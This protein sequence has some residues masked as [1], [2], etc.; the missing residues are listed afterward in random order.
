M[1]VLLADDDQDQLHLR[2]MVLAKSGFEIFEASDSASALKTAKEQKPQCAV[3]DLRF[4]TQALGLALIR[5]LKALDAAMRVIVLTGSDPG[6]LA[7]LPEKNLIDEVMVKGAGSARLVAKLREMDGPE[8]LEAFRQNGSI[9]LEVRVIPRSS[10]SEV[11]E[12]KEDGALKVKLCA[13]PEKGHANEELMVVL[14][15]YFEV[16]K[17]NVELLSGATSRRKRVRI[18]KGR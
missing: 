9:T 14:A 5:A 15:E 1:R 6:K 8:I 4:P 17:S 10:K 7:R 3:V 12:V 13:I 16:P 11:S 18:T 2:G